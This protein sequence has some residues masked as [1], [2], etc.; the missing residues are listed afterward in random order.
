MHDTLLPYQA[1]MTKVTGASPV[2]CAC[3]PRHHQ[4]REEDDEEVEEVGYGHDD[5]ARDDGK[6]GLELVELRRRHTCNRCKLR[7]TW[8]LLLGARLIPG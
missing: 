1:D 5:G 3:E 4:E 8:R 6:T 2:G 7:G